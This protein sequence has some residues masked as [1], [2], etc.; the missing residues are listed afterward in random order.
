[1]NQLGITNDF[2]LLCNRVGLQNFVFQDVPTYRRLT[3]E[4]LSS[5]KSIVYT[6]Q[7]EDR[8][9]FRLLN[10]DYSL[11][12]DEFCH[13][14]QLPVEDAFVYRRAHRGVGISPNDYFN[15][16]SF[17]SPINKGKNIQC[18][19]IRYLFYVI[20][21]TLQACNEFTRLNDEDILVLTK[22]T[23]PNNNVSLNVGAVL[24]R[25]LEFQSNVSQGPLTCGGV[26][27]VL[28]TAMGIDQDRKSVV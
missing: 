10:T 23:I 27:T 18:S 22:A 8:I 5:L 3:L 13:H 11:S 19:A 17:T 9:S 6:W 7:G 14:L 20:A 12:L 2:N 4:F 16:M 28:A 1:M 24:V 25:Y 26:I 21:N 15:M